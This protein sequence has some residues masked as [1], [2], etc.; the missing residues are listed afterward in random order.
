MKVVN[1]SDCHRTNYVDFTN[2]WNWSIIVD[3][4]CVVDN[5]YE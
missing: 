1:V 2:L 5:D 3:S 4:N